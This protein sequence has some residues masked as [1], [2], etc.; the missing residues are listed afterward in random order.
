[1]DAAPAE[2]LGIR[3]PVTTGTNLL[4]AL[5]CAWFCWV[6]RREAAPRSRL[7]GLFFLGMSVATLAGVPKHG[8]HHLLAPPVLTTVLWISS[9]ATGLSVR[10]AQEATI[11][12]LSGSRGSALHRASLIQLLVYVAVNVLMGPR[13]VV[14]VLNTALG[15]AP[16]IAIELSAAR[17]AEPGAARI[18]GGL[19]LGLGCGVVYVSELSLGPLLTHVDIA[20]A[21]MGVS[22]CLILRGSWAPLADLRPCYA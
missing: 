5:Q 21:I 6:L 20:H 12:S 4:L 2:L 10:W 9:M 11:A 17:R 16:I 3:A 8:L 19:V 7:W 14:L 15:L 18:A 22:Y 13:M 1:V